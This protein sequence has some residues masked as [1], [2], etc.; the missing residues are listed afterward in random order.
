MKSLSNEKTF[1]FMTLLTL[2]VGVD[3]PT[4]ISSLGNFFKKF[5]SICFKTSRKS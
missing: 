3:L 2:C 1:N 4:D 5:K